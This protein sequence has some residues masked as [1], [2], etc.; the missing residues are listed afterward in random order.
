MTTAPAAVLFPRQPS[1]A[2]RV[3]PFAR[4]AMAGGA[5]RLWLGQSLAAETH[6][7]F[8]YLAGAGVRHPV[9]LGVTLVPLRHPFEAALQARSLALLTGQP[10]VAGYGAATPDLVTALRGKPYARPAAAAAGYA[11]AV[12]DILAG[13]TDRHDC[14]AC[15]SA[16]RLPGSPHPLVEIGLGVLR[17]AM[18]R[19]A[20]EVAD[21]A[22]TWMTPALYVRDVLRPALAAGAVHRRRAPRIATVVHAAVARSGRDPRRLAL[23]AAEGHLRA[24]HYTDMLCRAG[25]PVNPA[26]PVSAAAALVETGVYAYGSAAEI[27]ARVREYRTAGVDE[28]ILNPAGVALTEGDAA[29]IT[30]LTDILAAIGDVRG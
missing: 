9:G 2:D 5:R 19:A 4:A 26:D 27:A 15:V 10:V 8:A 21:V 11:R 28:V 23:A 14:E 3:L 17:P 29:A 30:D 16:V 22:V 7:V 18:A 6:Q 12:R 1:H 13:V 25:V 20:G 24:K